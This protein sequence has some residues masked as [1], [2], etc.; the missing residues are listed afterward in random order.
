MKT[1]RSPEKS[2]RATDKYTI[3]L[4]NGN[5]NL[6]IEDTFAQI[7]THFVGFLGRIRKQQKLSTTDRARLCVFAAAMHSRTTA[8]GAHWRKQH[9]QLHEQIVALEQAHHTQPSLS[10]ETQKYVEN[11][12]QELIAASLEIEAPLLF[13]M[14]MTILVANDEIGFITSDTPCIWF[15]PNLYKFPPAFRSPGLGHKDIEVTLPLTPDH[16][17]M[18]SHRAYPA[19]VEVAQNVVD[20]SNRQTRFHSAQEFVSRNGETR[21]YWFDLG[22]EPEGTWEESEAG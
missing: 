20:E 1:K 7:E 16:L 4:P 3:R 2:F 12:H 18:I 6:A 10:L 17:L 22:K 8:A 21:P 9:Q 13:Q 11:A 14:Q 19:Y 5:R 15:N